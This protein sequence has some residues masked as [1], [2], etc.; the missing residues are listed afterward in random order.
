[1]SD[2]VSLY[3]QPSEEIRELVFNTKLTLIFYHVVRV[4]SSSKSDKPLDVAVRPL[5]SRVQ[6]N[7]RG[8]L[9]TEVDAYSH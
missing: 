1:M 7:N 9:P 4:F 5:K 3:D 8:T 6:S 2:N